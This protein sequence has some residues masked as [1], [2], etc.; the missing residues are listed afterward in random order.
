M[1]THIV[2]YIYIYIY[3]YVC[4]YV[5]ISLSLYIYICMYVCICVYVCMYIYIYIYIYI[6]RAENYC[7]AAVAA[8]I[9][10]KS[11]YGQVQK[12]QYLAAVAELIRVRFFKCLFR[13]M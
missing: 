12:G 4:I 10:A 6:Y 13:G 3:I 11:L 8:A 1:Y 5:S 7:F 9:Y 2:L